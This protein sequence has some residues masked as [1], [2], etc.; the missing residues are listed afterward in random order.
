MDARRWAIR[1][2]GGTVVLFGLIQ[3]IRPARTNP[4][5]YPTHEIAASASVDPAVIAIL[6]R[7]CY[8]CH[9]NRTIWPW[10]S[11]VAPVSWLVTSDVNGARRHMNFSEWLTYPP[12]KQVKLLGNICKRVKEADMP[13]IQYIP[14]HRGSRLRSADVTTICNWTDSARAGIGGGAPRVAR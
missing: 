8:D 14:M 10:Y 5:I 4:P 11:G 2:L 13:P 9:S 1:V 3:I 6:N 7:S 12:D